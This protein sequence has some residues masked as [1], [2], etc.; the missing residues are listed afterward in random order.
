M[1]RKPAGCFLAICFRMVCA[2]NWQTWLNSNKKSERPQETALRPSFV[3]AKLEPMGRRT[4][5][6]RGRQMDRWI[7]AWFYMAAA[8]LFTAAFPGMEAVAGES[9]ESDTSG[10][11]VPVRT[12]N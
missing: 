7:R 2:V 10:T 11:V 9:R 1:T 6:E 8:V 12:S 3:C 5:T 4:D